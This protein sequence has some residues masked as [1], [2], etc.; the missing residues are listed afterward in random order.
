MYIIDSAAHP[1]QITRSTPSMKPLTSPIITHTSTSIDKNATHAGTL[2]TKTNFGYPISVHAIANPKIQNNLLSVHSITKQH[3]IVAFTPNRAYILNTKIKSN[4]I[5]IGYADFKIGLYRLR[6]KTASHSLSSRTQFNFSPVRHQIKPPTFSQ[7]NKY[8]SPKLVVSP[9][10]VSQKL[11][12]NLPIQH[13]SKVSLKTILF[14]AWH[15]IFN[16]INLT[17]L[18]SMAKTNLIP[19]PNILKQ[20]PPKLTCSGCYNGKLRPKPHKTTSHNYAIG[21][22]MSSDVCGPIKPRSSKGSSYFITFIDLSSRFLIVYFMKNRQNVTKYIQDCINETKS[23]TGY[24]PRILRTDNAKHSQRPQAIH[25]NISILLPPI[26]TKK[27]LQI[28]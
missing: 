8:Q 18:Q 5:V 16:H 14:H 2:Q 3:G 15:L 6:T 10:T 26:S 4:P 1:T 19:L 17:K 13:H 25:S 28:S 20:S 9:P 27:H 12:T 21:V 22:A 23:I 11:F 24:P 7:T